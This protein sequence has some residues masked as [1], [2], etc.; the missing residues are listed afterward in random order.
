MSG[1]KVE[2]F[3]AHETFL[4]LDWI[5]YLILYFWPCKDIRNVIKGL[6]MEPHRKTL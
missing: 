6:G 3:Y 1:H 4:G 2:R 5:F